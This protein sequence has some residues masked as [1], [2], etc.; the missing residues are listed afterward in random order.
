MVT[1][2]GSIKINL[3]P[4]TLVEEISQNI[5]TILLTPKFSVPL[6]RRF[7][8]SSQFL[9]KPTPVSKAVLVAEILDAIEHYEP[10]V[11]VLNISFEGNDMV[12]KVIPRLEVD[13]IE[14]T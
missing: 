10:R 3:A 7:G 12:G 13:I 9:D 5:S 8:L 1:P 6:D 2:N 11:K 4:K 14:S